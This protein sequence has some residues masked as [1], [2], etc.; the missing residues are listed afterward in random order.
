[1]A[2]AERVEGIKVVR[3][4]VAVSVSLVRLLLIVVCAVRDTYAEQLDTYLPG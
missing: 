4:I 1:M 3:V 2:E